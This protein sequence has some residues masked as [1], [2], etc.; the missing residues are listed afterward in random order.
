V[1]TL[2]ERCQNTIADLAKIQAARKT[3]HQRA[4]LQQ[5]VA[6]WNERLRKIQ[7][8]RD[9]ARWAALSPA[10]DSACAA[11]VGQLRRIVA[12]AVDRISKGEDPAVLTTDALWKRL[13]VSAEN[14]AA[15]LTEASKLAWSRQVEAQ[16]ELETTTQLGSTIAATPANQQALA[17]YERYHADYRRLA[18]QSLPR[19]E[20]DLRLL[21]LAV[22]GCRGELQKIQHDVPAE[23][24]AFFRAV[25]ANVATLSCLT[26]S[27]LAWLRENGQLDRYAIRSSNQ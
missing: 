6:E 4:A 19:T 16:G 8:A 22:A 9:L 10:K 23:V 5:R 24:A 13:I 17:A 12:T 25:Y 21:R 11:Q 7:T 18:A 26:P 15:A 14:Y 1:T 3:A 20:D 2:F 27:V